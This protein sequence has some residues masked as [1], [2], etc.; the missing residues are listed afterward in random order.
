MTYRPFP[1]R[2]VT[3]VNWTRPNAHADWEDR[4]A[5]NPKSAIFDLLIVCDNKDAAHALL[6]EDYGADLAVAFPSGNKIVRLMDGRFVTVT[7]RPDQIVGTLPT[8]EKWNWWSKFNNAPDMAAIR[9][10]RQV[11]E[12]LKTT[13]N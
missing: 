12:I 8:F 2:K 11:E 6:E 4:C 13:Y 5:R 7:D 9:E 1:N 3:L 10:K